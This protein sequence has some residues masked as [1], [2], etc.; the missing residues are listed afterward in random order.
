MTLCLSVCQ[1]H[2][3][4][5]AVFSLQ[6]PMK[7]GPWYDRYQ[8]SSAGPTTDPD[9]PRRHKRKSYPLVFVKDIKEL[10]KEHLSL[11]FLH[12][13]ISQKWCNQGQFFFEWDRSHLTALS[14]VMPRFRGR[15]R[16]LKVCAHTHTQSYTWQIALSVAGSALPTVTLIC[17]VLSISAHWA[18]DALQ[19]YKLTG[20]VSIM[21]MWD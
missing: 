10:S 14:G 13:F 21:Y 11:C 15:K 17:S 7:K 6:K 4:I 20:R 18:A 9:T 16:Q 8:N 3:S 2:M 12:I 5:A 1:F 19:G